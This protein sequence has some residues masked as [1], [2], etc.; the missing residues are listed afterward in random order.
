MRAAA[1]KLWGNYR[2]VRWITERKRISW[3]QQKDGKS[4]KGRIKNAEVIQRKKT[5]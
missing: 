4:E 1:E 2:K 5:D 3:L